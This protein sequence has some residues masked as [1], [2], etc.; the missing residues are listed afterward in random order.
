M[1]RATRG[2]QTAKGNSLR[3]FRAIPAQHDGEGAAGRSGAV[4]KLNEAISIACAPIDVKRST[5]LLSAAMPVHV[6]SAK[7]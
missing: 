5:L 4:V 1:P 2:I 7:L 6:E 3:S